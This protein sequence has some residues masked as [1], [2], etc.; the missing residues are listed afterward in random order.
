MVVKHITRDYSAHKKDVIRPYDEY[1]ALEIFSFDPKHTRIYLPDEGTLYPSDNGVRTSWKSWACYKSSDAQNNSIYDV[2]YNVVENGDYRV[3]ILYEKS[4]HLHSDKSKNTGASLT[5]SISITRGDVSVRNDTKKFY[6]YNNVIRRIY[7]ID[8]LNQGLH[9]IRVSVPHNCYFMGIIVRKQITYTAK[10]FYGA[11]MSKDNGNLMLTSAT[12]TLSEHTKPSELVVDIGY[13][14]ALECPESPSGFYIDYRDEVNFYV[15]DN[16]KEIERIFGG[17]VSSILPNDDRTKL[18][19]HCADRLVDGQNKYVLDEMVLKG[20]TESTSENKYEPYMTRDFNSYGE[21]LK[22]LCGLHELGLTNNISKNYMVYGEQKSKG[23]VIKYGKKKT[24]KSIKVSNGKV[25][26]GNNYT[27]LRN[28]PSSAKKQ[29][30]TLYDASKVAK[31]PPKLDDRGYMHISYGMGSPKTEIESKVTEKVDTT[32]TNAGVQKFSKCGVSEDKKY[33]MA[34]GLPSASKDPKKGYTKTIF[35]RKCPCCGSTNLIWDW[36]W[37]SGDYGYSECRGNSEGGSIEGHVFCKSCD[38]DWSVQGHS[39]ENRSGVCKK[40]LKKAHSTVASSKA[41]AQ[42]LKNGNMKTVPKTGITVSPENVFKSITKIAKKYKYK[43]GGSSSYSAMKKSGKGDCWAFSDLILTE[44]KK[45][46]VSCK[47]VEYATNESNNHHSVLYKDAKGKWEDFPYREYGWNRMLYNTS[48]SKGGRMVEEYKGSNMGNVKAKSSTKKTETTKIKT[49]KNYD[50]SKPFQGYLK[51]TYSIATGSNKATFKSKKYNLYI[52]FS[53]NANVKNSLN[54][55]SFPLQWVNN[56]VKISTLAR[57]NEAENIVHYLRQV[58]NW[59]DDTHIFLQSIQMIAP[60]V[61]Q[62]DS[63]KDTDWY[64]SDKSNIDNSSCKM[65][66][67]QISFD[68]NADPNARGL[69]SCGKSVNDMIKTLTDEAHY[70]VDMTYG[71]HRKDDVINFRVDNNNSVSFTATEGDNNNILSWNSI[72][73]SPVSSLYNM[74][75]CIFKETNDT[76][77]AYVDTRVP[78]SIMQYQEQTTLQTLNDAMDSSEAYYLA[79]MSDKFNGEQTYTYTI[80]VPNY[81]DLRLGDLVEVIA[82]AKKLSTIKEVK[83][84]KV[85]FDSG[86][87]PRVRTELGLDELAPDIQLKQNIRAMRYSAKEKTT[88]FSS[89]AVAIDDETIYT[90]DK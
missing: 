83:S 84:I 72:S 76:T 43:L 59:S 38:A 4:N 80:T 12:H 40:S 9:N 70:L 49:T 88:S 60:V 62:T 11:D 74:S 86:K 28:N 36:H 66:L 79:R 68:N 47:I 77:Y 51:V 81:P 75:L 56:T 45:Y 32:D 53:Q 50:V 6:G 3:D 73:Y 14:D 13:D 26:F 39:H 85:S 48:K 17:Y 18:N 35:E 78:R 27:V 61:K 15:K 21:A 16:D 30:W 2:E 89:S 5:G 24:V 54:G 20:G 10:N 29:V 46:G 57:G 34:I 69:S 44:M 63:N 25:S 19:I 23:L 41:E 31:T 37:A 52:K 71:L 65:R 55:A 22:Y 58:N 8:H 7:T 1:V 82:N 64:K 90:W 87:I 33:L 42:K 67:Y